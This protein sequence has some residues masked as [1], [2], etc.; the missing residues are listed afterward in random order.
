MKPE[1]LGKRKNEDFNAR[2]IGKAYSVAILTLMALVFAQAL[3]HKVRD[4]ARFADSVR[5]YD[6]LPRPLAVPASAF[7]LLAEL[8][9]VVLIAVALAFPGAGDGLAGRLG[10]GVAGLLLA[11]YGLA[12]G[13]NLG[14]RQFGLD[15]GCTSGSMPIS[16]GLVVRN[17]ALFLLA[18]AAIVIS[19]FGHQA[20]VPGV[21]A[22]AGLFLGYQTMTRILSN[23]L[24]WRVLEEAQ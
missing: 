20:V 7:L 17:V 1:A 2:M 8:S 10:L 9:A 4:F 13:I 22:G 16:G 5:D 14:R 15:C 18:L 12:M 23:R 11:L 6:L 24:Q 19:D 3:A 21:A